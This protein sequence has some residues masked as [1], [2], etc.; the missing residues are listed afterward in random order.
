[1]VTSALW[2]DVNNDNW[3]DLLV[4]HEWGPVKVFVNE[5]GTLRD[6]TGGSD[7]D[8]RYGWWNSIVGGDLDA[9]GDIDYV[10]GNF[11]LNTKYRADAD[12]PL[13]LYYGDFAGD[14]KLQLVEAKHSSDGKLLPIRGRSCSS[15]AM[16]HLKGKFTSF[17]AFASASLQEIY[18]DECLN[19][20]LH[21]SA[22]CLESG[23]LLNETSSG[24]NP[25]FRF[26]PL[27]RL[28]Q[29][30]PIFGLAL[31]DVDGDQNLDLYVVQNFFSP[32]RET[33]RMDGGVSL[34]MLGKGDGS[35]KPVAPRDSALIAS[36]DAKSL[37][38]VDL[39]RDGRPDFIVGN[40][41]AAIRPFVSTDQA[42]RNPLVVV[43]KGKPGNT[44]AIGARVYLEQ[45][46]GRRLLKEFASTGG[47]LSQS[48]PQ[49]FFNL[50][51]LGHASDS[52][53]SHDKALIVVWPDGH[54]SRHSLHERTDN[55]S[56]WVIAE[57]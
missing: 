18:T 5:Q 15:T 17:Q 3:L 39:N 43:L 22:N 42:I 21:L 53:D 36:D 28:A 40:N 38:V 23:V 26:Q 48:P 50:D 41:N 10:V 6:H 2:S 49:L 30:S 16:P 57:N 24:G 14:G 9:D 44:E 32:Q 37:C 7:L 13:E 45:K 31:A 29:I 19:Q 52:R 1:M 27:P 11:G 51:A 47:Y 56:T 35:F 55:S 12:H 34:L 20:S 8:H 25:R 4:T 33:G 54:T 46:G